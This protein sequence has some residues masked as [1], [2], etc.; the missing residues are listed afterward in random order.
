VQ[1][2][3][4][5][6]PMPPS[7]TASP[8]DEPPQTRGGLIAAYLSGYDRLRAM[9]TRRTGC[10][11]TAEDLTQTTFVRLSDAAVSDVANPDHYVRRIG[12]NLALDRRR[13]ALRVGPLEEVPEDLASEAPSPERALLAQERLRLILEIANRM[14]QPR[15]DVFILRK[16]EGVE[17]DEV[18]KRLGISINMVQKHVRR[19]LD[20]IAKGLAKYD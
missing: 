10:S 5:K 18:A 19:A 11:S 20:D 15:R 4:P 7:G 17:P 12:T 16:I 13:M 6:D 1:N 9:L 3:L 14:P 8:E 2:P